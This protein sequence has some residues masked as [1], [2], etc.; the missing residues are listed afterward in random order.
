MNFYF[1]FVFQEHKNLILIQRHIC[2]PFISKNCLAATFFDPQNALWHYI[3]NCQKRE[4]ENDILIFTQRTPNPD[5]WAKSGPWHHIKIHDADLSRKVWRPL[6][7]SM[8][9]NEKFHSLLYTTCFSSKIK[10][11]FKLKCFLWLQE[12]QILCSMVCK[13]KISFPVYVIIF[14]FFPKTT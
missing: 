12:V 10:M 4:R 2:S 13:A 11:S 7:Y 3:K 6:T 1:V 9:S 14:Q 8:R 5:P